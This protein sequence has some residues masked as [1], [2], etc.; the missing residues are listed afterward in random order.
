M[1]LENSMMGE[2][3]YNAQD[4][5]TWLMDSCATFHVTL[6]M[7]W[8]SNHSARLS[9]TIRL[10]NGQDYKIARTGEVPIQL[11]NGNTI[12]LHQVKHVPALKR[13]LVSIGMLAEDRYRTTLNELAWIINRG[14]K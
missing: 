10:G 4:A 1:S 12:T 3:H 11:P 5:Q 8:F 13:S 14:V 9:S 2:F 7:E 6:N